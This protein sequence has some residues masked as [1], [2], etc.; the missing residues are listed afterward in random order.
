MGTDAAAGAAPDAYHRA[1]L[2]A[3]PLPVFVVDDD[4]RLLDWNRAAGALVGTDRDR[5]FQH[6]GG[7]VL[8][9]IHAT[10]AEEGCGHGPHCGACEI[11]GSVRSAFAGRAISR[12]RM[13]A[14][15][16]ADGAVTPVDLLVTSAPFSYGGRELAV[17]ILEDVSELD[18]LRRLLP[19][20][21][22]CKR[23]RDDREYWDHVERYFHRHLGVA[24]THGLCPEC[25]RALY[26]EFEADDTAR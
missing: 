3:M 26:P 15:L 22:R 21:A 19:I 11:R 8:H 10:D 6:R 13:L 12:R 14:E 18:A 7:E 23:I 5:V 20:C 4:L 1:L 16:R 24:F 2:D 25:A 17:L 9:C